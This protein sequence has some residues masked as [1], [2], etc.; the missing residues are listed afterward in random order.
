MKGENER[1]IPQLVFKIGINFTSFKGDS[2][3]NSGTGF[4]LQFSAE[5]NSL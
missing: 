2:G 4:I 5:K 1:A 3:I